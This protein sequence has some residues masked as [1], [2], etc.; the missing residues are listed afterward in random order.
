MGEPVTHVTLSKAAI[1]Y[2]RDG[3]DSTDLRLRFFLT[4]GDEVLANALEKD[5]V[6]YVRFEQCTAAPAGSKRSPPHVTPFARLSD[7]EVA[8]IFKAFEP[9]ELCRL[10]VCQGWLSVLQR[11]VAWQESEKVRLR[12]I[13]AH[14]RGVMLSIEVSLAMRVG[15]QLR[16]AEAVTLK[17]DLPMFHHVEQTDAVKWANYKWCFGPDV[18]ES[19]SGWRRSAALYVVRAASAGARVSEDWSAR[20]HRQHHK[21]HDSAGHAVL[22]PAAFQRLSPDSSKH[23]ICGS[24]H[25]V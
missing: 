8:H 22:R 11:F 14:M 4:G 20:V 6:V 7:D 19:M 16:P 21:R 17:L 5:D 2:L 25:T 9:L 24:E 12:C 1:E 23:A 13:G 10:A 15:E 3:K 18:S